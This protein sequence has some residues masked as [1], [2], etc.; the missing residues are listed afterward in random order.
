MKYFEFDGK[1]ISEVIAG[2]MRYDQMGEEDLDRH[3]KTA[4]D[5]GLNFFDHADIYGKG[6]SQLV[7]GN[8]LE[9]NKGI[10]EKMILQ[11]KV[12]ITEG[13][14]DFSKDHI[15]SS[16]NKSLKDLKTDYLDIL[17]L[18]R[19]DLLME[20]DEVNEAFNELKKDGKVLNFGVSNFNSTRIEILQRGL[21]E[22]LYFNQLQFSPVHTPALDHIVLTNTKFDGAENLDGEVFDYCMLNNI[23]IQAWSPF[24]H[25]FIEGSFV[26]N[27][28]YKAL[29]K[30]LEDL[31]DKYQ[32]GVNAIVVAWIIRL[33][34]H[35]KPVI[36]TTNTQRLL[37]AMSGADID[38]SR[39]EWYEIY[40]AAG[41]D[42]I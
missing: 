27:D 3:I 36:G 30:K 31:A 14:Y 34:Y 12:G 18:H 19:P 2:C 17:L 24:Q 13:R 21:D 16:V 5:N 39:E 37:D 28:D 9:K 11:S 25:G 26:V 33:P 15:I 1:N 35:I 7:F 20:V 41:H 4:L 42:I 10:R 40:K 38:L 6:K 32:V 23:S 22:K 29:N 8:F